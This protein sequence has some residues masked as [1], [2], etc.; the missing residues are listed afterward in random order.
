M[1][2][3]A[4]LPR[5]SCCLLLALA[6]CVD[7]RWDAVRWPAQGPGAPP[8]P[9]SEAA[10]T[11]VSL[12]ARAIEWEPEGVV[13]ELEIRNTGEG[14]LEVDREAI[15]VAYNE[16]EFPVQ[17]PRRADQ[18]EPARLVVGAGETVRTRL[19]FHLGRALTGPGAR[20]ILRS[21]R[22]EGV[23]IIELL[24]LELPAMPAR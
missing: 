6:G 13:V 20:L 9:V 1:K 7:A 8:Q 10:H 18:P 2:A 16:L 22:R 24:Q 5:G 14:A 15:F 21:S 17:S 3:M 12:R 19:R 4:R 11:G 23:A